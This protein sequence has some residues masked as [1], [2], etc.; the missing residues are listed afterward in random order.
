MEIIGL[1]IVVVLFNLLLRGLSTGARVAAAGAKAAVTGKEFD[2]NAAIGR[3]PPFD[4]RIM[5]RNTKTDNSGLDY[6]SIEVMGLIPTTV[7]RELTVAVSLFDVTD[8]KDKP[9]VVL[10]LVDGAREP[11]SSAFFQRADLGLIKPNQGFT[12][13]VEVGRIF[14]LFVQP[15]KS[16]KRTIET[17]VRVLPTAEI[18]DI[19]FGFQSG[20]HAKP[21]WGKAI[22]KDF[23]FIASGYEEAFENRKESMA[24]GVK[25]AMSVAM[26]DGAIAN[27]EGLAI[28]HWMELKA[29]SAS[30]KSQPELKE[31]LNSAM[32]EAHSEL[33]TGNFSNSQII[34]K[35]NDITE[36]PEKY[37]IM[38][39]CYDVMAADGVA[40][41]EE[42]KILHRIGEALELD[43]KELERIRD[44]RMVSLTSALESDESTE[45]L[46]GMDPSWDHQKKK[47]YIKAEFKKWNARLNNVS[48]DADREHAQKMLDLIGEERK[49]Y[50]K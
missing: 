15:P 29:M 20:R 11:H 19:K 9:A 7:A 47:N 37:E 36:M 12:K 42:L 44:T 34:S 43:T 27:E 33:E 39:L 26:S 46:L 25:L 16:G 13:W 48:N 28:K 31:K 1:I 21:I 38:E 41:P 17:V 6:Y 35:I 10:S 23:N 30:G 4:S 2:Y 3:I 40:D 24:L 14:P 22:D 49:K 45:S 5:S 8:G 50:D 32:K 18:N